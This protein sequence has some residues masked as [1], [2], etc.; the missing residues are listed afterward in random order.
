[1]TGIILAGFAG[2]LVAFIFMVF[3]APYLALTQLMVETVSV[4]MFMAVFYHL[5]NLA[6]EDITPLTK[7][8]NLIVAIG[9]GLMVTFVSIRSEEHT[10]ELQSRFDLVCRLLLETKNI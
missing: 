3:R 7:A 10:S 6:K 2:F 8:V 5:P 4:I 1:M 9:A